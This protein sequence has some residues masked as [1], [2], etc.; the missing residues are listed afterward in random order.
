M[1]TLLRYAIVIPAYNHGIRV[2][3]VVQKCLQLRLPVIVV[4]DGST[5]STRDV[6]ASL[7]GVMVIRH[8]RNQ[9]K[10]ASLL[11]GFAE[12]LHFADWAVTIDADGQ[13]NPQD[14]PSLI[15]LIRTFPE[16]QRPLVIGKR[17]EMEQGNVPWTS[18]WGRRFANFWVWT[19]CGRWLSDAQSGFRVYPLPETLRLGTRARR[20]QFEVEVLV[21]AVWR[22]IPI[23]EAPVHAIY[24][25]REDRVSHFR[26]W[27]DFWRNTKTF[28]RLIATR[29]LIPSRLRK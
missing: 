3:G 15:S 20:Y 4:D 22:G 6:L 9:G 11:T 1:D 28:T 5:D 24:G 27:L 14:I 13:H 19:S 23:I 10:G 26:P 7:S 17:E 18:R 8:E 12:A 29:I 16:G 2:R 25:P 21:R